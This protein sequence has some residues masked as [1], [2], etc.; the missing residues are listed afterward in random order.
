MKWPLS[1][2][3][4]RLISK[5]P[6]RGTVSWV[7]PWRGLL[8]PGQRYYW[9]V[10]A[11]NKDGL[12]GPWSRAFN[13]TPQGPGVPLDVRYDAATSAIR[14]RAN[15][16]GRPPVKWRVYAS[17]EKGF[18]AS[19]T[20]HKIIWESGYERPREVRD[21]PP[22]VVGETENPE[23]PS[24]TNAFYRVVAVDAQGVASGSSDYA[25]VPRPKFIS[26]PPTSAKAGEVCRYQPRAIR[27]LGDLRCKNYTKDKIY[28]AG[29]WNIEKPAWTL[30]TAPEWLKLNADTG[31]LSG[32][33]P[34]ASAS[35]ESKIELRCEISGVGADV[36]SFTLR[37]EK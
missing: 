34:P 30:V 21:L 32:T 23:W 20:P 9:R 22:N 2:T 15:P 26:R 7:I 11:R 4:D 14:W 13:F 10:R 5:T 28:W 8:N 19:D 1:P 25:A 24:L 35:S 33:P 12:W 27:S 29:Y 31:E 3:F 17:D 6:Q 18:T 16:Q 37:V 36:Q